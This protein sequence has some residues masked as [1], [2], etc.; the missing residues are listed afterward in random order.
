MQL[1]FA[2]IQHRAYLIAQDKKYIVKDA[3]AKEV[4]MKANFLKTRAEQFKNMS[5]NLFAN[6]LPNFWNEEG[7][8]IAENEYLSQWQQKRDD[9]SSID[10]LDPIIMGHHIYDILDK[11]FCLFY[12][13]RRIISNCLLLLTIYIQTWMWL[14]GTY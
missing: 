14:I 9:T 4:T 5:R 12:E 7:A 11:E 2:G 8:M 13:V 1:Q 3:L 10:Q 6:G